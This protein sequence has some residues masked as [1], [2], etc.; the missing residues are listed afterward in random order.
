MNTFREE[1]LLNAMENNGIYIDN[2]DNIDEVLTID[3][4]SFV[5]L[6]VELE[7]MFEISFEDEDYKKITENDGI[8]IQLLKTIIEARL[9]NN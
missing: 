9:A 7:E 4:I 1:L 2:V 3:S 6:I 5:T 8:T